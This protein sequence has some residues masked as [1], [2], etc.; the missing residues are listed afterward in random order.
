[1]TVGVQWG[2]LSTARINDKFVAGCARSERVRITAVASRDAQRARAYADARGIER[3]HGSYEALLADPEVEALYIPLPNALH[4]EWA[5]AA[6]RAG[7]HV[8][9]EKPLARDP[10]PVSEV[11]DLAAREGR[12]LMEGF[13]YRHHPQTHKLVELVRSGTVGQPLL[14]RAAFSFP[15]ASQT[16]VRLD[17]ALEGGALMDV[18]CY[19]VNAARLL[20]G[21]PVAVT[22]QQRRSEKGVDLLMAGTLRF[23]GGEISHFDCGLILSGRDELEV[24]GDEGS[25]FLDDPWHCREPVIE[26]RT[27]DGT[28]RL[29]MPPA[30]SY[31]LEAE[32]FSD[33]IR[34][35]AEP[36]L[37]R[38]DA[39]G[40]ATTI[41]AL[42]RAAD[43]DAEV[44]VHG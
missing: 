18:G 2:I 23:G 36:L 39:I 37:G 38:E 21:E 22:A 6:L 10:E 14:I 25:L 24:V 29:E 12:L 43:T 20:A 9:C 3:A 34:G 33:A 13:M 35:Q 40:Q 5:A 42:Y 19:C 8:L 15:I 27:A 32:N 11:F 30:D 26:V 16:D 44:M 1:V 31:M 4:L 41:A 17:P 28:D 7:K